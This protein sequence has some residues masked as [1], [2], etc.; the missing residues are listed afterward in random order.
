MKISEIIACGLV[1][2]TMC[3]VQG[4]N[5]HP[6]KKLGKD[7]VECDL[8]RDGVLNSGD[9]CRKWISMNGEKRVHEKLDEFYGKEI[10]NKSLADSITNIEDEID[11]MR[12]A[13]RHEANKIAYLDR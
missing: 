11:A 4:G 9:E 5:L 12:I 6:L 1:L 8:N 13:A 3:V 7:A 10:K 2:S